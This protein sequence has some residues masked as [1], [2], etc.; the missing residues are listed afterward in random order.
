MPRRSADEDGDIGLRALPLQPGAQ[1]APDDELILRQI[2]ETVR[3]VAA[4]TLRGTTDRDA[5]VSAED[6]AQETLVTLH[7]RGLPGPGVN[8]VAW[9]LGIARLKCKEALR[10]SRRAA[11]HR[12]LPDME[13]ASD[14]ADD[15][16]VG[17]M[18]YVW[19]LDHLTPLDRMIVSWRQA[20]YSSR[21]IAQELQRVGWPEMTANNVDQRFYRALRTLR[22]RL[23]QDSQEGEVERQKGNA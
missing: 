3:R 2:H 8:P 19:L 5:L 22:Q 14:H 12:P 23:F 20:G 11:V 21:E 7:Q 4:A 1:S 17:L 18:H 9:A 15:H 16:V 13:P 10:R 6:I